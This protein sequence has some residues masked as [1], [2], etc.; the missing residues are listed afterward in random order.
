[1]SSSALS[2]KKRSDNSQ[3]SIYSKILITRTV[4]LDIKYIGDNLIQILEKNIA[5]SVEG[6]CIVEGLIKPNSIKILTYSSGFINSNFVSFEVVF[7][8][9]SCCP[10]E[11]MHIQCEAKNI[12]KAGIRA[13]SQESPSPI[14]VFIARDHH[15]K[16]RHYST[17]KENALITV[18]VIGQRF[19]LNDPYISI[20]GEL[21]EPRDNKLVMKNRKKLVIAKK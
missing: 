20:I 13:V 14:M 3:N 5:E 21:I 8:C 18:R 11:G 6:K 12:T 9:L 17:V 1:M 10:V 7:E 4:H 2:R 16:S 15:I 19:E